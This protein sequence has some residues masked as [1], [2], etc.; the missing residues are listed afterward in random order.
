MAKINEQ[1]RKLKKKVYTL[2]L[3]NENYIR[4]ILKHNQ[5][6]IPTKSNFSIPKNSISSPIL[7]LI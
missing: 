7:T 4:I 5:K 1:L 2:L 3:A 6:Y